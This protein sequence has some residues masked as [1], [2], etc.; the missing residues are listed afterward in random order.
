VSY[1]DENNKNQYKSIENKLSNQ[2]YLLKPTDVLYRLIFCH[3]N[4]CS[5]HDI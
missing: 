3:A 1:Q 2:I 4:T 5:R